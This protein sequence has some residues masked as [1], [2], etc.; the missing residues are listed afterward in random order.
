MCHI[1][2]LDQ[3]SKKF[4]IDS[5]SNTNQINILDLDILNE[6][7][8]NDN[9]KIIELDNK[10]NDLEHRKID[11]KLTKNDK[12]KLSFYKK[13][14]Q[15][16]WKEEFKIILT[17]NIKNIKSKVILIGNSNLYNNIKIIY[18]I[19]SKLKYI[20]KINYDNHTENII[21]TNLE[22]YK[23]DIIK[24]DFPIEYISK[25]YLIKKRKKFES[26][27]EGKGYKLHTI[28]Q[29]VFT[30]KSNLTKYNNL[31]IPNY[32]FCA[33][34]ELYENKI[35]PERGETLL[36]YS[37][38]VSAVLSLFRSSLLLKNEIKIH[39][40]DLKIFNNKVFLYKVNG[41]N[42]IKSNGVESK[43]YVTSLFGKINQVNTINDILIFM[44]NNGYECSYI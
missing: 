13:K 25:N 1:V 7:I 38:E 41:N 18:P 17:E 37:D 3:F 23:N 6:S 8:F 30:I 16:F 2:G 26:I 32:L 22:N 14:L 29:I 36:A 24:G 28:D 40:D 42:F 31:N 33:S 19:K 12:E 35:Y 34:T 15:K 4:I 21:K 44:K 27:Y 20:N 39:E 9:E 5:F 11:E 10:I 43:L